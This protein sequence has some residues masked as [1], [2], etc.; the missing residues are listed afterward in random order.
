M[1]NVDPNSCSELS[2]ASVTSATTRTSAV[3]SFDTG[4]SE[5][6]PIAS[7]IA[8]RSAPQ[9]CAAPSQRNDTA[10]V[11]GNAGGVGGVAAD[12]DASVTVCDAAGCPVCWLAD[13]PGVAA[14]DPAACPAPL[15]EPLVAGGWLDEAAVVVSP[16]AATA[17]VDACS[18]A[19][20]SP[21][22]VVAA[23][24]SP[25]LPPSAAAASS[26]ALSVGT[27]SSPPPN[28]PSRMPA[29]AP[30]TTMKAITPTS[31][32]MSLRGRPDLAAGC[33]ADADRL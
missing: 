22:A 19:T 18:A 7:V 21:P 28:R 20:V 10:G 33:A 5:C 32:S 31:T 8:L 12:V 29:N 1:T 16:D 24:S 3:P 6:R 26:T 14:D 13:A 9:T 2:S 4:R 11:S 23:G 30:P 17:S 25:S 27:V 15:L